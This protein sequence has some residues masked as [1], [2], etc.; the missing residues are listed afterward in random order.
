MF[1]W[2]Y[3]SR[4]ATQQAQENASLVAPPSMDFNLFSSNDAF[5]KVWL[6]ERIENVLDKLSTDHKVSRPDAIRAILFQHVYGVLM[7]EQFLEWKRKKDEASQCYYQSPVPDAGAALFSR[8]RSSM[9]IL[10]KSTTNLKLWLPARLKEDLLGV[11]TQ[12][13]LGVSDYVRWTLARVLLGEKFVADWRRAIQDLPEGVKN[14]E[15]D[16]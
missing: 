16:S 11:A 8:S 15:A 12:N 13:S 2:P 10:G 14:D 7:Y 4:G 3:Q 1:K 5:I 6:P 9:E